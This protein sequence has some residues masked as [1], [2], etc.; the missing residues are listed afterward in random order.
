MSYLNEFKAYPQQIPHHLIEQLLEIHQQFK[1]SRRSIFRAQGTTN[2]EFPVLDAY[3]N[4]IN[5]I[6]NPHIQG[7]NS[8]FRRAIEAIIF[9]SSVSDCLTDFTN[10]EKHVNYQSMLFDKSTG[11][12]LHQDTWYLDTSPAGSLV[13]VWFALEDIDADAGAFCLYSNSPRRRV[14]FEDYNFD[15]LE[16]DNNFRQDFPQAKRFDFLPRKGDILIW[17]SF[18]VHGAHKPSSDF[19]TRKSLTAHFYPDAAQVQAQPIKRFFSIYEHDKP[20][21]TSNPMLTKAATINPFI[22]SSICLLAQKAG[23]ITN[24]MIRDKTADQAISEI[25]QLD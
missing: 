20:K 23:G 8:K 2:F 4:Q 7:Y 5:S 6:Q 10:S 17:N 15:N 24:L 25:R 18:V 22:Y 9:H 16:N 11:T 13:G 1:V 12:K 14:E 3:G 19:K 21:P